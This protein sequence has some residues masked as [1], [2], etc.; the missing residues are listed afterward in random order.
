VAYD[1]YES[2]AA[3]KAQDALTL[4]NLIMM[5]H[6]KK[7]DRDKFVKG[8]VK[9]SNPVRKSSGVKLSNKDLMKVL[10]GR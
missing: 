5:P 6:M 1:Y 9:Q 8:L 2:I 4:S 10:M 7:G 3:I